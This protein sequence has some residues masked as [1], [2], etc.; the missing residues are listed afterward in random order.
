MS[1]PRWSRVCC[2]TAPVF[3][4]LALLTGPSAFGAGDPFPWDIGRQPAVTQPLGAGDYHVVVTGLV[5]NA[6]YETS[7]EVE[8][9]AVPPLPQ[10][11]SVPQPT[12][13]RDVL[14]ADDPCA[15]PIVSLQSKFEAA[16]DSFQT[17]D[18]DS[19]SAE[20]TFYKNRVAFESTYQ[21]LTPACKSREE[22][23]KLKSS[24]DIV[25]ETSRV[26]L[27][28]YRIAKGQ[29]LKVKVSRAVGQ[30]AEQQVFTFE[31][32]AGSRG[33]WVASYGLGIIPNGDERYFSSATGEDTFEITRKRDNGGLDPTA[34]VFYTWLPT[35]RA[36][37]DWNWGI[38]GG[39]GVDRSNLA[40]FLGF[41]V[42]FNQ[43]IGVVVGGALHQE[44]RLRGEFEEGQSVQENLT[45][46]ALEE[47][48]NE[49]A[50]FIAVTMR[51]GGGS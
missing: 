28:T 7:V 31:G 26:D 22:V 11:D 13:S 12:A 2:G 48:V 32:S 44:S 16:Y 20:E 17:P 25:L 50:L 3:G 1:S 40:L 4:V 5:R 8:T 6:R 18:L 45:S 47:K 51:F 34:A 38:A 37:A 19:E 10:I 15:A 21:G 14:A 35:E 9:L 41:H 23:K 43:N 39:M 36:N 49:P 29:K 33:T 24:Y 42:T 27:G 46:D 30:G